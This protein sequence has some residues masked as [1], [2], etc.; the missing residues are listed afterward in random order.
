MTHERTHASIR[1]SVR[2]FLSSGFAGHVNVCFED[3]TDQ[4]RYTSFLEFN[5]SAAAG[6]SGKTRRRA[7][8]CV[9]GVACVTRHGR[10][11]IVSSHPL[12]SAEMVR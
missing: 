10:F 4:D 1:L 12:S 9:C 5:V 2:L 11:I 7:R 3:T 8:I 6:D